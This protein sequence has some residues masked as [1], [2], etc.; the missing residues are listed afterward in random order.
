MAAT[1]VS[2]MAAAAADD[3]AAV[4][5]AEIAVAVTGPG[6]IPIGVAGGS[7][8]ARSSSSRAPGIASVIRSASATV[9]RQHISPQLRTPR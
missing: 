3:A 4:V 2:F 6:A 9:S 8:A 7:P 5:V 1:A